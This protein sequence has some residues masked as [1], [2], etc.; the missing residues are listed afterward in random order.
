MPFE[1]GQHTK[2]SGTEVFH[3]QC[4]TARSAAQSRMEAQRRKLDELTAENGRL[5]TERELLRQEA[6]ANLSDAQGQERH[7]HN[8][9]RVIEQ[10]RDNVTAMDKMIKNQQDVIDRQQILLD[11]RRKAI[12]VEL[13]SGVR[14]SDDEV[15]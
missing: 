9:A 4:S 15:N 12:D 3:R 10:L 14:K 13:G 7:A 2:I 6:A 8:L 5:R 1:K 11:R